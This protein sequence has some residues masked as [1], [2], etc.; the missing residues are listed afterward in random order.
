MCCGCSIFIRLKEVVGYPSIVALLLIPLFVLWICEELK[1]SH[2][3][4]ETLEEIVPSPSEL[5]SSS[6][7]LLVEEEDDEE[8]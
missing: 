7:L 8:E 6:R 5:E 4:R 1:K 3:D 2:A